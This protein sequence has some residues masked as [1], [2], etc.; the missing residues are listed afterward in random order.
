MSNGNAPGTVPLTLSYIHNLLCSSI[1]AYSFA[2]LSH[3]P[4]THFHILSLY[5]AENDG[6]KHV[7]QIRYY[8]ARLSPSRGLI[9]VSSE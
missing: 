4:N 6:V 9:E 8:A 7:R 3:N 2:S 5:L 1:P